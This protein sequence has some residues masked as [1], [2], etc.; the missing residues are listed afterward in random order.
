MRIKPGV[1]LAGMR[2]EMV[3]GLMVCDT[4]YHEWGREMVLTSGTDGIHKSGSLHY[5]GR[6]SDLRLPSRCREANIDSQLVIN[7]KDVV[8]ALMDALG[9]DFDVV[10]E[11]DHVHCEWDPKAEAVRT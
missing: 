6:G 7:D 10:L 5:Q 2:P 4:V 9:P 11:V 3:I 8:S 1:R